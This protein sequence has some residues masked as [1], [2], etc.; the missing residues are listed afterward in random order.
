MLVRSGYFMR[1]A[2]KVDKA[3]L[4]FAI[5]K[6]ASELKINLR[7]EGFTDVD[8][9][10]EFTLR[11]DLQGVRFPEEILPGIYERAKKKIKI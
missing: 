6:K 2:N 4:V 3:K 9:K 5:L 1:K 8:K 10:E 7:W 11:G